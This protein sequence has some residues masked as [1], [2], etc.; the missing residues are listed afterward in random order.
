[1]F[2]PQLLSS[3]SLLRKN[4]GFLALVFMTWPGSA[5]AT[6]PLST[7]LKAAEESGYDAREQ[8]A[9]AAQRS[10]ETQAALGRLLPSFNARGTLTHNQ[11]S[12]E[13]PAGTF[14]GQVDPITIT[15]QNQFDATFTLNV[16]LVDAAQAAR[17]SQAKHLEK[18]AIAQQEATGTDLSRAV[19]QAYYTFIGS[20]ALVEAAERSVALAEKNLEFVTSR[21]EL[22]AAT[23]L[24][25]QRARANVE[26]TQRDLVDAHLIATS[27]ARTLQTLSGISPAPADAYPEDDLRQEAPLNEWLGATD[28]PSDRVARELNLAAK[29]AKRAAAYSL[30][31]TLSASATERLTNATGF[32]GQASSYVLQ[33][34]LNWNLDYSTYSSAKAQAAAAEV[35]K[36]RVERSRRGVEDSIFDAYHRVEASI[37][38]SASARAEAEASEEAARLSL[39]GYQAGKITQLEVT[40]SQRDAFSAHAARIKADADLALARVLL[41]VAAGKPAEEPPSARSVAELPTSELPAKSA[42]TAESTLTPPPS[43][44]PAKDAPTAPD[45]SGSVS[46]VSPVTPPQ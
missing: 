3:Y 25:K 7:F 1:M 44:E 17:Y 41:R 45:A 36:I 29:S 46:P 5:G 23:K 20:S 10:F 43:L 34:V 33:A 37:A 28:T 15:P 11:Y 30:F 26:R 4:C 24:D 9:T 12:A 2:H 18:A 13:L 19:A 6:E 39:E 32:A 35:Q 8:R 14:P 42:S 21:Q 31:P 38:K 40:Q 22:G 27:A 16:P